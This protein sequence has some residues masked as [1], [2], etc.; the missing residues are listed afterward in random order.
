MIPSFVWGT[1]ATPS[2]ARRGLCYLQI[3]P[4]ATMVGNR[5][6]LSCAEGSTCP[7]RAQPVLGLASAAL[8]P[9]PLA[10]K[11]PIGC[12]RPGIHGVGCDGSDGGRVF[13][14]GPAGPGAGVEAGHLR[15]SRR[16][17]QFNPGSLQL[18][19]ATL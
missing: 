5:P 1:P 17:S 10:A 4:V 8:Q 14:P 13:R 12:P 9:G 2:M 16:L 15:A 7:Q 6:A 19:L 18:L 3:E 11:R